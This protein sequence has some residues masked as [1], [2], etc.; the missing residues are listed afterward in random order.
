ML[1]KVKDRNKVLIFSNRKEIENDI[2][3]V[4][5]SHGYSI[6]LTSDIN[7]ACDTIIYYKPALF[8]ADIDLL[9]SFPAQLLAVFTKARK[10]PTF[11]IIDN[12]KSKE[13]LSRY[14]EYSDDIIRVP[15]NEENLYYKITKA[16][17]NN[18]II[19]DNQYYQG[20]FLILKLMIPLLILIVF[21]I[22]VI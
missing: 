1:Q 17:N 6:D 7:E 10:T 2:F 18:K 9:P 16:V 14:L 4:L 8:V 21:L 3:M 12:E 5:S 11:L 13:K 19:C 22:T 15:F 20:I